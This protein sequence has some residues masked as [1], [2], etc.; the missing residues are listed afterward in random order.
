M[1]GRILLKMERFITFEGIEGCG[2]TTQIKLAGSFL[3]QHQITFVMTEEPGGTPM[4][5]RIRKILLNKA[6]GEE[7]CTEAEILLFSAARIQHVRN[8]ILPALEDGKVVLCD[9]FYDATTAYQG[10]GRGADIRFIK[11]IIE[12]SS[13]GLKPGRTILFDLPVEVGLKRAMNR[14]SLLKEASKEAVLED[15]FERED[16]EFHQRVRQGYLDLAKA[17]PE[18][19][20]I[21]ESTAGIQMIHRQVRDLMSNFIEIKS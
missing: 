3:R 4:G 10:F 2:K 15:R 7:I 17:E 19:F 18:R 14:I 8:V 12:Y 13:S 9:R 5:R 20:R 21:I 1:G 16:V 6:P 11:E